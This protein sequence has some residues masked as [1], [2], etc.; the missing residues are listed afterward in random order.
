MNEFDNTA[1]T[2]VAL[3]FF[4]GLHLAHQRVLESAARQRD[5]GLTPC[6]LLFDDHP[7]HVLKGSNVPM[8]L[9]SEKRDALLREMGLTT[10]GCSFARIRDMSP[11]TFVEQVLA[12][13]LNAAFVAC[14][15]NY[16]FGKNGAGDA[17]ALQAL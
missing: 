6:V 3:G 1:K 11:R 2:A 7:Q 12:G 5:N 17:A 4:D 16:R 8:L 10:V 15:Y 14:G 13:E 9:Q